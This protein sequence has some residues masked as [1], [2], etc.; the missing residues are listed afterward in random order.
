[1]FD[2]SLAESYHYCQT[3]ARSQARNF[4]YSFLVLPP[5]RRAAMCVVY[6][7]FRYADDV[8][9]DGPPYALA[10]RPAGADTAAARMAEWRRMLDAAYAGDTRGHPILPAFQDVTRRYT[11]PAR[12]FHELIEGTE[13]DL[14]PRRYQD[15]AALYRYCYHVASTVG[16]VC[17]HIF[18]FSHARAPQLAEWCGVAFQLTNILR[19]L[20]E[21][22]ER[23]R[24][25]LPQEDLRRFGY[26]EEDLRRGVVNDAFRALMRFQV[27]RARDYYERARPLPE[28]VHPASR[29]CLVA[30][31]QIYEGILDRIESG[32]YDVF[33]SRAGLPAWTKLAIA[34]RAWLQARRTT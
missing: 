31:V 4:Y 7:F 1:M 34:G 16:L 17:L 12:Y 19:D 6:A 21:D 32:G 30:M 33:R 9:D 29:P 25:Y 27:E 24:I 3:I 22:A 2:P 13:M 20:R 26:R 28:L 15:F 8:S 23:G 11:I 14:A 10:A 5:E 18:G